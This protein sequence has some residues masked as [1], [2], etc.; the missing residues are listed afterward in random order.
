MCT[1]I[2]Y[3]GAED[4]TI[5]A[6]TMDWKVDTGSNLWAFPRGLVRDGAAGDRS[7]T[8]T[9]RYG[10]V[11]T[12]AY[13]IA[14]T[15]GLNEAGLVANVLW[16]V[17]SGYPATDDER[18]LL[19]IAAWTQ[20]VLDNFATVAEAVEE[21]ATE[22][23]VIVTD[24]VPGEERL[25]TLHLSLSDSSGDSAIFEYIDGA[26]VIHHDRAYQVMTNSPTFDQQLAIAA[27]WEEIGGTVMLPGTNRAADRFARAR[28]YVNAVPQVEDRRVSLASVLSVIRSVSVPYGISTPDQPNISSTQWRTVA[29]HK[30]LTYFFDSAL[31]PGVFWVALTDMD[32]SEG[33]PA[34]RLDVSALQAQGRSGEASG[35]F[36]EATPFAFAGPGATSP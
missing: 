29:D 14:T 18:P 6:R 8:W 24:A 19:S 10:S 23:F 21:L 25:T 26:L 15:D 3:R 28:F 22:P 32:L 9:S 33:A 11:I 1:R 4:R 17:E 12:S 36:V 27:Y 2:L 5:T 20:Y 30:D 31:S 16:L 13:D 34:C 7:I 35:D